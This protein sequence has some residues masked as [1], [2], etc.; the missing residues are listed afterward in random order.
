MI[1]HMFEGIT[2]G[3]ILGVILVAISL[4]TMG[5]GKDSNALETVEDVPPIVDEVD[6][7]PDEPEVDVTIF[8]EIQAINETGEVQRQEIQSVAKHLL[9]LVLAG[10]PEHGSM[11]ILPPW[12]PMGEVVPSLIPRLLY[13]RTVAHLDVSLTCVHLV[14]PSS[15]LVVLV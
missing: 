1:R 6:V 4:L 10:E 3:F 13:L 14:S 7:I 8:N 11:F 15:P 5:C 9:Q 2:M 12:P